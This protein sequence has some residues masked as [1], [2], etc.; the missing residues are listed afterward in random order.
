MSVAM[1]WPTEAIDK[2]MASAREKVWESKMENGNMSI[3]AVAPYT[4]T[5]EAADSK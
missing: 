2:A 1:V 4:N 5:T 3:I